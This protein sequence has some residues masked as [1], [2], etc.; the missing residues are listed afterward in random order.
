M[1]QQN[2]ISE[3]DLDD[4]SFDYYI[5]AENGLDNLRKEVVE[6]IEHLEEIGDI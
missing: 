6:F 2:H 3:I 1:E 4:F 5:C